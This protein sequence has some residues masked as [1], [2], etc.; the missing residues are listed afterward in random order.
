[1]AIPEPM[2]STRFKRGI[3][4]S[5]DLVEDVVYIGMGLLLSCSAL[6]LL[7]SAMWTF[8][9]EMMAGQLA[10]QFVSL[11]DQALFVLLVIELLYTVRVSFREHTL[12]AEPF[13]LTALIA[14]VRK[15]LVLTAKLP[16][17]ESSDIAFRHSMMELGLLS[18]LVVVLV[19]SVILL[20]RYMQT[21]KE[22]P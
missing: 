1:M 13:L 6:W 4:A 8:V 22:H 3:A 19:A 17:T 14:I 18:V 12:V 11:L 2:I 21:P 10:N 7:G 5:L 20:H 16:E 15:I 9:T